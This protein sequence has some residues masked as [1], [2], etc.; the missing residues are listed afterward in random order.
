MNLLRRSVIAVLVC[1]AGA[2]S[3]FAQQPLLDPLPDPVVWSAADIR[4]KPLVIA[5]GTVTIG[6]QS[7]RTNLYN[8]MY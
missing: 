8:G 4:Q 5:P 3:L 7:M 1:L 6:T 2:A